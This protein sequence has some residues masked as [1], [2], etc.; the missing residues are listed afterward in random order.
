ML[1]SKFPAAQTPGSPA[2][3]FANVSNHGKCL[4]ELK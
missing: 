1:G 2:L 4:Q 3:T